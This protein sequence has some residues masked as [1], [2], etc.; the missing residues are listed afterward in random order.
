MFMEK[1]IVSRY[2]GKRR[3][4]EKKGEGIRENEEEEEEEK[5]IN[6]GCVCDAEG[7]MVEG[8]E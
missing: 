7:E 8:G 5:K 6:R 3:I 1:K 4:K 2:L